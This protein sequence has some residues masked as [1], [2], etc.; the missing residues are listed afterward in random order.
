MRGRQ[1]VS[2]LLFSGAI[3]CAAISKA[4]DDGGMALPP[5]PPLPDIKSLVIEPPT[6]SLQDGRDQRRALVIGLTKTGE[7]IDLS[8]SAQFKADG[9]IVSVGPDGY[10]VPQKA[11]KT[12]VAVSAGGK[13][14]KLAVIVVSADIPK[15]RYVRDVMPVFSK[16]GCNAGVCHGAAQG[17]NGFKMSLRGYDPEYDYNVLV[18]DISG[19]RI[20]RVAPEQSL[21][22]L[23]PIAEVPHEGKQA[24][25]PGSPYYNLILQWIA[26]GATTESA[27]AGRAS[28]LE[29]IPEKAEFDLP[30]RTQQIL[31]IAHYP[32]GTTRD[33][34]REAVF[35]TSNKDVAV[36][37]NGL[38]TAVRRGESAILVRYEGNYASK[39][40]SVMG[41]RTGFA[42][43][44]AP[45]NN[46][47]D[48][49]VL[50]K[51]QN[52]KIQPSEL[53]TD[54]DFIRRVSLDLT[55]Q[56]PT[57]E[58]A[59]AFVTD[60]AP[61]KEKREKLIDQLIGN[62]EFVDYW[63]SRWADLLQCNSKSLGEKGVWVFR[64][65]LRYSIDQNVP[66]DKFVR[67]LITAKG[68]CFQNPATNY[69]R[70]LREPGKMTEDI[71][72]TFLGTRFNCNKC[73]DHPFERWTQNQYYEF[74]AFFAR[75]QFK[76][77]KLPEEEVVYRSLR[78]GE[79]KSPKT[80]KDVTPKVPFGTSTAP[81]PDDDRREPFIEWMVSKDNPLFAKSAAN[82]IWSYFFGLGVI[83]PVDDIRAGNPASNPELLDAL[84]ED[85]VK[86]G[87]DLRH[88]MRTICRSRTYQLSVATN[89][90][91][92][93][94]KTNF[95]HA[96]PRRLSAEQMLDAVA[97]ATGVRPKFS[98]MPDGMR[99][100]SLADGMIK[101]ND[102]LTLFGRPERQSSCECERTTNISLS[103]TLNLINGAMIGDALIAPA[104]KLDVFV[105]KEQD[106]KKVVEEIYYA[107]L[108]R[109]PTEKELKDID[110]GAGPQ[111]A[112][113]AQ[114]LA[115]ALM[116]S[117][118]FIFNR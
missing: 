35:S 110:L 108:N 5:P 26:E 96:L 77:G 95:S 24:I 65:W 11:G 14:A 31:V 44:D 40:V 64:D 42:W 9:G 52:R 18:N 32:D 46:F 36:V 115:W 8:A 111:R 6:L 100:V 10:F 30:G 83:D 62:P 53:C 21:M 92:E 61:S 56:P 17:K 103:H 39:N 99:A 93:D 82:R 63:S 22:L 4:S 76:K 105:K 33:V 19:R 23:K 89:K 28:N 69:L 97:V 107:V 66:Y 114:D 90:W 38:V 2:I 3:L 34:T 104:S 25:K 50:A 112:E 101:G 59:R 106:N 70:V 58:K 55:G 60:P 47:I 20:N 86:S 43:Q 88:L 54:A 73:H 91:N 80:E 48:T 16:A 74:G 94:D 27:A 102:F 51:L 41:D 12:E 117:P 75:V 85:F 7:R 113:V 84:T 109:P 72:Q 98:G 29:L 78:N 68:S 71:S 49:H 118:A 45:T 13:K 57:A 81:A 1:T 116:N 79:V 67:E 15:V 37:T 87:F